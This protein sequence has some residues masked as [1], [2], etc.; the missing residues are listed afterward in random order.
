MGSIPRRRVGGEKRRTARRP[1]AGIKR[2][3]QDEW[4]RTRFHGRAP[5]NTGRGE[6]ARLSERKNARKSGRR[7]RHAAFSAEYLCIQGHGGKG[8]IVMEIFGEMR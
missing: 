4:P 5:F 6:C 3:K 7:M 8:E 2:G 1:K